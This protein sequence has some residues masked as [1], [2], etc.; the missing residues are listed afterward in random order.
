MGKWLG[1]LIRNAKIGF[2][3]ALRSTEGPHLVPEYMLGT[4]GLVGVT[5]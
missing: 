4:E 5:K 2:K 1:I 3:D